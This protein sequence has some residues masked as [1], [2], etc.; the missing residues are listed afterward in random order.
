MKP[1]YITG[2]RGAIGSYLT[3][4]FTKQGYTVRGVDIEVGDDFIDCGVDMPIIHCA[5]W[6]SVTESEKEPIRYLYNNVLKLCHLDKNKIVF[7]SSCSVYGDTPN[8]KEEDASLDKCQSVYAMTKL[9]G[10][11]LINHFF[12]DPLIL[13]LTNV[14]GEKYDNAIGHFKKD[15]PIK[16]YGN[17]TRDFLPLETLAK[18]IQKGLEENISGTFNIG[19]G[20]KTSILDVA[21]VYAN[22]RGVKLIVKPFRHGEIK[23][24][25]VDISKAKKEGLL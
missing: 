13:R 16:V 4:Y 18:A 12:K 6:T 3:D 25:S 22:E 5:A 17:C 21:Q 7:L 14:L 8:A 23:E 24:S 2:N 9:A 19:S 10:E 1:I 15:N 11:W 20:V